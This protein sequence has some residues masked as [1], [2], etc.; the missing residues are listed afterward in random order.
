MS[1]KQHPD[2]DFEKKR[3]EFTKTYIRFLL[4]QAKESKQHYQENMWEA[5]ADLNV[6]DSSLGYS[7]LLTNVQFLEMTEREHRQLEHVRHKPYFARIDFREGKKGQHEKLYIGKAS[8]YDRESQKDIIVDW[9]SPVANVY[10]DSR[11]GDVTYEVGDE[12]VTGNVSLKRQYIIEDGELEEIRDIDITTHDELLQQALSG[13]AQNRLTDI[14]ST[15]QDEQNRVI[16]ADL[17]K[18]LIVQGVAGSGKTTIAL[19]RI[20]YFIYKHAAYFSP[21]SI[22]ILAPSK[23]FLTYI[24]EVLPELGVDQVRQTTFL[25]FVVQC[26][27]PKLRFS[28]MEEDLISL[29]Q[30]REEEEQQERAKV[31]AFKGSL[32]FARLVQRYAK[33]IE[34]GMIPEGDFKIGNILVMKQERIQELFLHEYKYLP[35]YKRIQKL[36][37]VLMNYVRTKKVQWEQRILKNYEIKLG[38][39]LAIEDD[40]RRKETV[41]RLMEK[42][43]TLMAEFKKGCRT[44]VN[45]YIKRFPK[46][47][48]FDYYSELLTNEELL[49]TY[50]ERLTGALVSG[51]ASSRLRWKRHYRAEDAAALLY[52]QH[53]LYGP[54][55]EVKTKSIVIDEAQDYTMFELYALKKMCKTE[56]F[57][58]LGDLSQGIHSYRGVK[59]WGNVVEQLFPKA[60]YLTLE[61]SYRTTIE[62][63]NLANAVLSSSYEV[64]VPLAIPVVRHGDAPG[65]IL[66]DDERQLAAALERAILRAKADK[67]KSFAL[68]GKTKAEC[69]YLMRIFE[70]HSSLAVELMTEQRELDTSVVSIIPIHVAKGLEFDFV[71][72]V[73]HSETYSKEELDAQLLYV[74]M[75]RPLHQL[76]VCAKRAEDVLLDD[77]NKDLFMREPGELGNE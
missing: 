58:I 14:V 10:Y 31:I 28:H 66:Y 47:D 34:Q 56:L 37:I 26:L 45:H 21:Q 55:Q 1:A 64:K 6:L 50:D 42:K 25:E 11:L 40:M 36:K 60:N 57:T 13:S 62:I 3:L 73:S 46:R 67:L 17:Y 43:E 9:R 44:A 48:V 27:D 53:Y 75:T 20:A 32:R 16:R 54:K 12:V 22:M 69:E 38:R 71:A 35:V 4:E 39:A 65:F 8:L 63:M 41:T 23:L 2:Y 51:L 74:G 30:G 77:I 7:N 24:S 76:Y 15:I 59:S 18:P 68:L 29:L 52:L 61:R 72:I 33:D 19:H 49:R 70:A 5:Y